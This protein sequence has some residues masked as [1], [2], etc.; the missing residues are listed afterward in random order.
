MVNNLCTLSELAE[1]EGATHR[2]LDYICREKKIKAV[3]R[4]GIIRLFNE[5]QAKDIRMGLMNIRNHGG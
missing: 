5:Q 1:R 2:Q 4:V 3:N